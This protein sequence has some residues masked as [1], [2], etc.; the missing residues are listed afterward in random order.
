MS[1]SARRQEGRTIV[2]WK[3]AAVGQ[4]SFTF[5]QFFDAV[6]KPETSASTS[7]V[8]SQVF[9]GKAKEILDSVDPE[10]LN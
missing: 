10:L 6:V 1:Y 3:I 5:R 8:F 9:V 7:P 4:P 2:P